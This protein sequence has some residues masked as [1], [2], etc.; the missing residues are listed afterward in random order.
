MTEIDRLIK[1][2][3]IKEEY[4]APEIRNDFLV[5]KDRKKIYLNQYYDEADNC[6]VRTIFVA[7]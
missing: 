6:F 5:T 1:N 7:L 3:F 4:L 2:G